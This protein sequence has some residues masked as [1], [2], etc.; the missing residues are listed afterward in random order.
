MDGMIGQLRSVV[1]D[2][3]DPY[4]LASFYAELLG[5]PIDDGADETDDWVVLG[6]GPGQHPRLAFQRA[7]N[8]REPRWPDP[9]RPQ[10]FHL[11]VTVDDVEAAEAQVLK[12]GATRLPGEGG[13]WRVYADPAGHPFC[14]CWDA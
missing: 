12:L 9:D 7:V 2:C 8:L 1:L 11:D 13:D 14:L 4:A 5:L 6:G 10:Q 3:P